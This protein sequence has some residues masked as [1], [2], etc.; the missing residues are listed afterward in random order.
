MQVSVRT[1]HDDGTH[2]EVTMTAAALSRAE[3]VADE[4]SLSS[5]VLI[6]CSETA[7]V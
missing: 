3:L 7:H 5:V 4:T 1:L 2:V 6:A